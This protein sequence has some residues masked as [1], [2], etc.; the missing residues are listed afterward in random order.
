VTASAGRT[1]IAHSLRQRW[2]LVVIR[3]SEVVALVVASIALVPVLYLVWRALEG[4]ERALASLTHPRTA[5][6]V[7]RSLGLAVA[8]AA[9]SALVAFPLAVLTERVAFPGRRWLAILLTVPL[10]V[11]SY[12]MAFAVVAALGPRGTLASLLERSMGLTRLPEVYGFFGAWLTLTLVTYPYTFLAL[13]AAL[14]GLDPAFEEVARTLHAGRWVT[15]W[16]VTVPLLGPALLSGM[17]LTAL[18]VLSDFGAIA[19]LRYPTLTYSIYNQYRLSFDR[20]AAAALAVLLVVLSAI[21]VIA[22][23]HWQRRAAFYRTVGTRRPP[24][25]HRPGWGSWLGLSL[26]L[27]WGSFA[28]GL[29]A[30]MAAFWFLR[31]RSL[32]EQLPGIGEPLA[33]S[34]LVG[35]AAGLVTVALALPVA[36]AVVRGNG[37]YV[38][39]IDLPLWIAYGLPGIVLALALVSFS[40]RFLP[41]LYQTLPLLIVGYAL[42]FLPEATGIL[43]ATLAQQN[44]RLE[45]AARTLGLRPWRAWLTVQFPL[46][47]PGIGSAFALV[48]LTTIKE[49]PVTLLLSPIGFT[50]LAT[51]VWN[52]TADAF[53]SHAALPTLLLL[54]IGVVPMAI[55]SWWQERGAGRSNG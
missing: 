40:V 32:G 25:L 52:A 43:R 20:S 55:F 39:L 9:S 10:A 35:S 23:R 15:L 5:W 51:A 7:L 49:L 47:L 34:L 26:A 33:N 44:P 37:R 46:T 11:P 21:L 19:I 27:L 14:R 53:W 8:V 3:P 4:G 28:I 18:Y 17:L 1:T 6:L 31:A 16:R 42:R 13:R 30:G 29:P 38:S 22:E 41:W 54:G 48:F 50:T 45:E 12:V 24:V 36:W 2:S